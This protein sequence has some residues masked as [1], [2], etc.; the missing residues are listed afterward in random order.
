MNLNVKRQFDSVANNY[1]QQRRQLIPCFDQF[2]G[3][4]LSLLETNKP[5]PRI[6]DLGAGTGLFSTMVMQQFPNASLTLVDFS[7]K[8][9]N[10]AK[11]RFGS[12]SNVSY[13]TGDYTSYPFDQ[14]YDFVVSSLSIHHL[15][16]MGKRQLFINIYNMLEDGGIFVNADQVKGAT[17]VTDAYYNRRWLMSIHDSGLA[18]D[19]INASIER[20]KEDINAP[21]EDQLRWMSQAGFADVDCMFKYFEFAVLYGKKKQ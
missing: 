2:Y 21:L 14:T 19:A 3:M 9:L 16:H 11:K 6:L 17:D 8:M 18:L 5:A 12:N 15:P 13:I 7:D 4:A 20:R 10:E 1:D